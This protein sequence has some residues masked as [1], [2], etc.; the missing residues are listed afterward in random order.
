MVLKK[1]ISKR[2]SASR[3]VA[4]LKTDV[5]E[6]WRTIPKQIVKSMPIRI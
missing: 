6:E 3:T 4:G 1:A 2:N 5:E